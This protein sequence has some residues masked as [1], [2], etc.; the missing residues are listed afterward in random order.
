M[1]TKTDPFTPTIRLKGNTMKGKPELGHAPDYLWMA[2]THWTPD[3]SEYGGAYKGF[4]NNNH[5]PSIFFDIVDWVQ[6]L[7][8]QFVNGGAFQNQR[9]SQTRSINKAVQ[10]ASLNAE[11][12]GQMTVFALANP[13]VECVMDNTK[14]NRRGKAFFGDLPSQIGLI[15]GYVW[16]GTNYTHFRLWL[17]KVG[18]GSYQRGLAK[19]CG[20]PSMIQ[21]AGEILKGMVKGEPTECEVVRNILVNKAIEQYANGP[22]I[23]NQIIGEDFLQVCRQAWRNVSYRGSWFSWEELGMHDQ[24]DTFNPLS[25]KQQQTMREAMQRQADYLLNL[26]NRWVHA[27]AQPY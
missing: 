18:K 7:A 11:K 23:R 10:I 17:T 12:L 1:A 14:G 5:A 21:T 8:E 27:M 15:D 26:H 13:E 19:V 20:L 25:D 2:Q 22:V 9:A 3:D 4:L 24:P 6:Y 16:G